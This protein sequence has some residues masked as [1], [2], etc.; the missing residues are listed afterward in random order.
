ML[1]AAKPAVRVFPRMLG[2]ARG[3][4]EE[5]RSWCQAECRRSEGDLV[6]EVGFDLIAGQQRLV[7]QS[8]FD[9]LVDATPGAA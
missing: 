8:L 9:F 2:R 3:R 4:S 5:L 7:V 6:G 1:D